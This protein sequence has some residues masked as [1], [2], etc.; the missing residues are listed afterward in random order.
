MPN[1]MVAQLEKE[2]ATPLYT[3]HHFDVMGADSNQ[4]RKIDHV[5]QPMWNGYTRH[6]GGKESRETFF[7]WVKLQPVFY[8]LHMKWLESGWYDLNPKLK[9][10]I[11][12]VPGYGGTDTLIEAESP[13]AILCS[14]RRRQENGGLKSLRRGRERAAEIKLAN[15][16]V[17][18]KGNIGPG[19]RLLG[20]AEPLE[21]TATPPTDPRHALGFKPPYVPRPKEPVRN[22]EVDGSKAR[23]EFIKSRIRDVTK[24]AQAA[25]RPDQ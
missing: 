7:A 23:R 12:I 4:L 1:P 10:A 13:D 20:Y 14:V 19:R 8:E 15:L 3:A 17:T 11:A 6:I 2:M 5:I 22:P 18:T 24:A 9:P 16:R 25:R 21:F